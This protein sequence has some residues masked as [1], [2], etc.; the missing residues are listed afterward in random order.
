MQEVLAEIFVYQQ[1]YEIAC[2]LIIA[3]GMSVS[4]WDFCESLL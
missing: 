2:A 4:Y 3:S 1:F